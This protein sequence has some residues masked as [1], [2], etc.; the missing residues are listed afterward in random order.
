MSK[1]VKKA[2]EFAAL[3]LAEPLVATLGVL[4]YEEPTPVQCEVIPLMLVG[5]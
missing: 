1:T 2:A 5:Q 4:G 3:G